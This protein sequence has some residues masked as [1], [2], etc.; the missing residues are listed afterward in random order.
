MKLFSFNLNVKSYFNPILKIVL[1]V[2]VIVLLFLSFNLLRSISNVFWSVV[3]RILSAQIVI[4]CVLRIY[5]SFSEIILVYERKTK[6]NPDIK[7]AKER[8]KAFS[9]EYVISLLEKCDIID[10]SIV[11]G[12]RILSFGASSDSR[13]G[14]SKLFDKKYYINDNED[15]ELG[16]LKEI[17]NSSAVDDNVYVVSIDGLYPEKFKG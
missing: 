17:L 8:S 14:C 13:A 6:T 16:Y 4:L 5:I 9:V 3:A 15:V 12:G 10:I 7:S 2:S 1:S 11:T